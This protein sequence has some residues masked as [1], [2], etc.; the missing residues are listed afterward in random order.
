MAPW[1]ERILRVVDPVT[2]R[3][4]PIRARVQSLL[5]GMTPR[6]RMLLNLLVIAGVVVA[7]VL[8]GIGLRTH[9]NGLRSEIETRK[10]QL[11]MVEEMKQAWNE[12][13]D[14]LAVLE[15]KVSAHAETSFSAFLEKS[16]DRVSLRDNLKQVRELSSS[17]TDT[18]EER[19]FAVTLSRVSLEQLVGF[20][21]EVE[22]AGY[23][24]RVLSAKIKTVVV[25][26]Q[27]LLDVTL[28]FS[29]FKI[30]EN[31]ITGDET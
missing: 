4:R 29:S 11:A 5:E 6:D 25:S 27:K 12:D 20:L 21:Y 2:R 14:T 28:E 30:I 19:Q 17:T 23:P 31:D 22:T 1:K 16:A 24:L 7:F 9:I 26:G 10:N 8:G 3:V 15:E 13:R 18:L